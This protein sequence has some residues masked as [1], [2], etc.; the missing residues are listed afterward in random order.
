MANP[1]DFEKVI[2]SYTSECWKHKERNVWIV[3]YDMTDKRDNFY[4]AFESIGKVPKGA[5]PWTVNNRRLSD[6]H[7]FKTLHEAMEAV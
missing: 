6:G 7:G 5:E 3:F 2:R 1:E 4:E